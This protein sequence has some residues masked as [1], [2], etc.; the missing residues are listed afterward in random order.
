VCACACA[1]V[2]LSTGFSAAQRSYAVMHSVCVR[3]C[4]RVRL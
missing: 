2:L 3:V 4:L 1:C